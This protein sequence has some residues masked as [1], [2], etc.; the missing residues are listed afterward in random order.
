[1]RNYLSLSN[2]NSWLYSKLNGSHL[3]IKYYR[4]DRTLGGKEIDIRL[5][6]YLLKEFQVQFHNGLMINYILEVKL[7]AT[8]IYYYRNKEKQKM[9]LRNRHEPWRNY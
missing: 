8:L 1:M 9:T 2:I 7:S 3:I 5:R 4:Y 6:D